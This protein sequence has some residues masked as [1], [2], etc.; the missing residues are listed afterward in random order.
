MW[1]TPSGAVFERAYRVEAFS[2]ECEHLLSCFF[3]PFGDWWKFGSVSSFKYCTYSHKKDH[4]LRWEVWYKYADMAELADAI[5]SE[6]IAG[7]TPVICTKFLREE[8]VLM[9]KGKAASSSDS[10]SS[11]R[12]PTSLEAQEN[13]MI[14]LAVQCAEKQLRDGTA[15]SQVITH[16]LKLGSS[17][18]RIEKE[19]MEKQKELIE[20]KTKNLNSNSEAKEMYNK[21]LEAFRRYSGAGG[22]DDE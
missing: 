21:A 8:A 13:L 16:Y 11:L 7:S 2:I 14:S 18:E 10:N 3:S 6:F 22:D 12:P 5:D 9:P 19:I 17:K 4:Q 1:L 15:S 20:A